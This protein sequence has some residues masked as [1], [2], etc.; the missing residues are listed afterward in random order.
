M[1]FLFYKG[2]IRVLYASP[3]GESLVRRGVG[4]NPFVA[5]RLGSGVRSQ[6][7]SEDEIYV[8][9]DHSVAVIFQGGPEH[10]FYSYKY[11]IWAL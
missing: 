11:S 8:T 7:W 3:M 6:N 10:E 4:S 2:I 1:K 9:C 5:L